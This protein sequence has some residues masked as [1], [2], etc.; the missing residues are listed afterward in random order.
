[1]GE[2]ADEDGSVLVF[3]C[4]AI[5]FL[6]PFDPSGRIQE[7]L[8]SR[9]KRMAAGADLDMDLLF[10][11]L[12]LDRRS[13]GAF[14]HGT[15]NLGVNLFFHLSFLHPSILTISDRFSTPLRFVPGRISRS[16]ENLCLE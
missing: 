1:V 10:R 12:R 15:K 4:L 2:P 13:A 8:L 5:F 9:K 11:A 16:L 14:D 7:L 6:E 3:R